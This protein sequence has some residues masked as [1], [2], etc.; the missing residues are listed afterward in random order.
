[1]SSSLDGSLRVGDAPVERAYINGGKVTQAKRFSQV[2]IRGGGWVTGL[3]VQGSTMYARTDIGGAYRYDEPDDTWVPIIT[4]ESVTTDLHFSDWQVEALAAAPSDPDT[5]YAA[6]G[7]TGEYDLQGRVLR[8]TNGGR[9]WD[10]TDR[11]FY[12]GGNEE[13]RQSGSR[14]AVDPADPRVVYY[15]T[16]KDG[17]QRSLDGGVTW[18]RL[19][20][21]PAPLGQPMANAYIGTTVVIIDPTSPVTGGRHQTLWAAV[22]GRGIY[23]SMNGGTSW[24]E[25]CGYGAGWI[26]D[27][28]R[29]PDGFFYAVLHPV[30]YFDL[31]AIFRISPTGAITNVTPPQANTSAKWNV[32]VCDPDNADRVIVATEAWNNANRVFR[33]LNATAAEPTW[34]KMD[35]KIAN[36]AKG[37]TWPLVADL[38]FTG[39]L[40]PGQLKFRD[41]VLWFAEGMGMWSTTDLADTE[42][43]LQH[44]SDGIEELAANDIYKPAGK[45]LLAASWDRGLWRIAQPESRNPDLGGAATL[46]HRNTFGSAWDIAASPTDPNFIVANLDDHVDPSGVAYPARRASAYSTDAGASWITFEAL[47]QGTAPADLV[48]GNLAVSAYDNDNLVWLPS[49]LTGLGSRVYF[50]LD[51]GRTWTLGTLTGLTAADYL[52]PRFTNDRHVLV[53]H[54]TVEG[55]FYIV[56][57]TTTGHTVLW[58]STDSGATWTKQQ[59][60]GLDRG[61]YDHS[62][63]AR[64]RVLPNPL[65]FL[66][67]GEGTAW[68][69]SRDGITWETMTNMRGTT[70]IAPGAPMGEGQPPALYTY[71]TSPAGKEGLYRS[72]DLGDRWERLSDH[73]GGVY[74]HIRGIAGDP[75][76]PGRVYLGFGGVGFGVGQF[77]G[78]TAT[79]AIPVP[80]QLSDTFPTDIDP[81]KWSGVT[82]LTQVVAGR[83]R[84]V[85]DNTFPQ[86]ETGPVLNMTTDPVVSVE[87]P[88]LVLGAP[89]GTNQTIFS[90]TDAAR[91]NRLEFVVADSPGAPDIELTVRGAGFLPVL[92]TYSPTAHRWLRFR[93]AGGTV[94]WETSPDNAT[95]TVRKSEAAPPWLTAGLLRAV[96]ASSNQFA[97][98]PSGG[99]AEFD[100]FNI[101]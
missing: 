98:P 43:T 52:H 88:A 94:T 16:R 54:P 10:A 57:A 38:Q 62:G 91:A 55:T 85:S 56:G 66:L 19:T 33:T 75:V 40:S 15:G 17:L 49:L 25:I 45:P 24:T 81:A 80:P 89:L 27:M 92:L 79:E 68:F 78:Y 73:P 61:A 70:A 12:V 58:R 34:Q 13:G 59:T 6:V 67:S 77:G 50:T 18:A 71:G 74:Q 72:I 8:S 5:V 1:M 36:G 46:P 28:D 87:L 23:R 93:L 11:I 65:L 76:S 22:A 84:L 82:Y 42:I 2:V 32:V 20:G 48:H 29:A 83:L 26:R 96:L 99:Y 3:E 14:L 97:T 95:W 53:A 69:R 41:G 9:T 30:S 90:I 63:N 44:H 31:M 39:V 101:H 47:V 51:R 60:T 100:N 37:T 4:S 86:A 7:A 35:I 64:L 21:L